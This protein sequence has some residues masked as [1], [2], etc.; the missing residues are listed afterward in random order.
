[1]AGYKVSS[2]GRRLGR[3]RSQPSLSPAFCSS[4]CV[5]PPFCAHKEGGLG[6]MGRLHSIPARWPS[7]ARTAIDLLTAFQCLSIK[8]ET[9]GV[10]MASSAVSCPVS[11]K[12]AVVHEQPTSVTKCLV[13]NC[14]NENKGRAFIIKIANSKRLIL[15]LRTK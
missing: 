15:I 8:N 5:V 9:S 13:C 1:M 11:H 6:I 10:C 4:H 2:Q 3:A 7:C 14:G 12:G